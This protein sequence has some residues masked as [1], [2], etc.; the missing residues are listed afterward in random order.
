MIVIGKDGNR[1]YEDED[2]ILADGEAMYIPHYLMD[3]D[4]SGSSSRT[5]VHDGEKRTWNGNSTVQLRR[6]G[7]RSKTLLQ[8][9]ASTDDTAALDAAKSL[10]AAYDA[11]HEKRAQQAA[12]IKAMFDELQY[13]RRY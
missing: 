8:D 7:F 6:P 3:H 4:P 5:V 12:E 11:L 1:R 13:Q 9:A 10:N 2:Y